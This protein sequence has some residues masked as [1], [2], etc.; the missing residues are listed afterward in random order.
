[1][2][3]YHKIIL[4]S[5][6]I[7]LF[8]SSS[9]SALSGSFTTDQKG[10]L[11]TIH[12]TISQASSYQYT[13]EH[14]PG[15]YSGETSTIP[16]TDPLKI[17]DQYYTLNKE[18]YYRITLIVYNASTGETRQCGRTVYVEKTVSSNLEITP[19]IESFSYPWE[20]IGNIWESVGLYDIITGNP[21]YSLLL[22]TIILCLIVVFLKRLPPERR[23]YFISK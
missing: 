1:M 9:V 10:Y 3:P 15:V 14:P 16:I 17:P 8:C 12:P 18:G 20:D 7:L 23:F 4:T 21:M 22:G 2:K 5:L 6:L 11:V 19:K 13:I